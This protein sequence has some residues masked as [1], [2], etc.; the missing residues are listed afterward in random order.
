MEYKITNRQH[1]VIFNKV[2]DY[3]EDMIDLDEF[4]LIKGGLGGYEGLY[5]LTNQ[6]YKTFFF[7]FMPEYWSNET[8]E[9]KKIISESP[10]LR[11]EKDYE[12]H[13]TNMFGKLWHEPMKEF[14]KNNFN[15]Q[16]KTIGL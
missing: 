13:L 3:I 7:I 16:I 1:L 10:L 2:Y 8:E 4:T 6:D 14:V 15:V 11:I 12:N 5:E 9:G